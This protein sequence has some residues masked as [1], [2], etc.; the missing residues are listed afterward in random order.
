MCYYTPLPSIP[1]LRTLVCSPHLHGGPLDFLLLFL[2]LLLRCPRALIGR[3]V[4]KS[5][6][7]HRSVKRDLL[8]VKRDLLEIPRDLPYMGWSLLCKSHAN[9]Y[10]YI[11]IYIYICIYMY[12]YV[13]II[14]I[15]YKLLLLLLYIER[16]CCLLVLNLVSST[17]PCIRQPGLYIYGR[18]V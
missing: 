14:C 6:V 12:I 18:W 9:I 8:S 2:P 3:W 10:I 4:W 16:A 13:Y 5:S 1:C 17:T 7:L 15:Y 11:Y